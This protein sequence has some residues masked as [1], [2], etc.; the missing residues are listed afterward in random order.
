MGNGLKFVFVT[1]GVAAGLYAAYWMNINPVESTD[2]MR[3]RNQLFAP[4]VPYLAWVIAPLLGGG[5]AMMAWEFVAGFFEPKSDLTDV[6]IL[7]NGQLASEGDSF[8]FQVRRVGLLT[9]ALITGDGQFQS[10]PFHDPTDA[11]GARIYKPVHRDPKLS[12]FHLHAD[13]SAHAI[14]RG[15]KF[16]MPVTSE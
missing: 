4:I 14:Y 5:L 11:D 15:R 16:I 9:M 8:Q 13:G 2:G 6:E 7:F 3:P 12:E 10:I 1:M